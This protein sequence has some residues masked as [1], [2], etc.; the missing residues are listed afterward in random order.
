MVLLLSVGV[1]VQ[2]TAVVFSSALSVEQNSAVP[3]HQYYNLLFK[4]KF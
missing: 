2:E 4:S 1:C 3:L